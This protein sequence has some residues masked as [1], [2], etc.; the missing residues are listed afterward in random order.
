MIVLITGSRSWAD[1]A[2][3][4]A[5]LRGLPANTTILHGGCHCGSDAIA[6]RL[7]RQLGFAVEVMPADWQKHGRAAGPIR[8]AA[9]AE[10][11]TRAIAF[12]DGASRGTASAIAEVQGRCKQVGVFIPEPL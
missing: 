8:N 5:V 12:W 6:D 1:E 2:T 4:R 10:R 9:M 3:I 11:C 7:A